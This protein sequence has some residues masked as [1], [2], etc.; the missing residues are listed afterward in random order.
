M[1]DKTVEGLTDIAGAGGLLATDLVYVF[2]PGSPDLDFKADGAD[3]QNL[4]ATGGLDIDANSIE[5]GNGGLSMLDNNSSHS[6]T[7]TVDEDLTAERQLFVLVGNANRTLDARASL[8]MA[9]VTVPS[10]S[11]LTLNAIPYTIVAAPGAGKVLT[12]E[13]MYIYKPAGTA[14]AGIAAG[15]DLAVRYTSAAGAFVGGVEITGFLDQATAQRRYAQAYGPL[16]ATVEPQVNAPL[17][18]HM[19]AG[20]IITGTSDLIVTTLYRVLDTS[21]VEVS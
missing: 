17:V 10:A 3:I 9:K 18:L 7:V 16:L 12:L 13:G 20:E 5:V 11:V 19:A 15:E 8:Q 14:Y 2:R 1:A 4:I 21:F 6:L